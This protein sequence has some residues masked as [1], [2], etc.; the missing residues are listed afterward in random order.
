MLGRKPNDFVTLK[1]V[2]ADQFI[3]AYANFLKKSQKI[4]PPIV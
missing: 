4:T 2:P 3:K 1:D